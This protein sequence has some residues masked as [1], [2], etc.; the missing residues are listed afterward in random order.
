MNKRK[1]ALEEVFWLRLCGAG[2]EFSDSTD[3]MREIVEY[4]EEEK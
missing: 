1:K 2:N 4:E 3:S